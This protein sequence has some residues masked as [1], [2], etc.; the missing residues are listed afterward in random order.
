MDTILQ[1][2]LALL[3]RG[4]QDIDALLGSNTARS[5]TLLNS[6]IEE[7][8]RF[9][10]TLSLVGAT[11]RRELVVRHILDSLAPLG[12]L[13]RLLDGRRGSPLPIADAGSGAGLPGIPLAIAMPNCRFTLIERKTR[14]A[15]FLRNTLSA[16]GLP[17]AEAEEREMEKAGL[18]RF[19]LITF[20]AFRPLDAHI[21]K[22]LFRLLAPGG[23]LAAYKGRQEKIAAEMGAAGELVGS[24][25]AI[26]CLVPFLDDERHLVIIPAKKDQSSLL[27]PPDDL[28]QHI[29]TQR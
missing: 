14:R 16:L 21:L 8:E 6:Y 3:C 18:N 9:N 19:D 4:D 1:E 13:R 2:G 25:E 28:P 26:P 24:W 5:L 12:I 27:L 10:P 22:G 29:H 7:I 11:D 17:N 15:V 23:V 20:R